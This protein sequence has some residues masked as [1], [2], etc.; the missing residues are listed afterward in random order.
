M[1]KSIFTIIMLCIAAIGMQAQETWTVAGS[2]A[3]FGSEWDVNDN[4]NNMTNTEGNTWTLV[5]TGVTL[6]TGVEYEF[7]VVQNHS[8]NVAYPANNWEIGEGQFQES[9]IYTVTITFYNEGDHVISVNCEKTGDY[10]TTYTVVGHQTL[11]GFDWKPGATANDMISQGDGTYKL[12]RKGLTLA[13]GDYP[14]KICQDHQWKYSWGDNGGSDNA[15]LNIWYDGSLEVKYDVTF[16]FNPNSDPKTVSAEAKTYA[17]NVTFSEDED[18]TAKLQSFEVG[19]NSITVNR[20]LHAGHWNTICLPFYMS[21]DNLEATFGSGWKL[22]KFTGCQGETMTFEQVYAVD[23][24]TP[25]L[26][27]VPGTTDITSF[28][29]SYDW[30]NRDDSRLEVNPNDAGYKMIGTLTP[31]DALESGKLFIANDKVYKST[32]K[33]KI[34]AMGAYFE[35]PASSTARSFTFSVD[36]EATGIISLGKDGSVNVVENTYDLQGHRVIAPQ[37]GIYIVNGKKVIK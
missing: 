7:K 11:T 23:H 14:Y 20:T 17:Y 8:W 4:A 37:H 33:S 12:E 22:A 25:Y 1:K 13:K 5:K 6:N 24:N 26:L 28:T 36:G 27:W 10:V 15:N 19:D 30:I 32:G 35:V 34:K 31:I 21:Y 2:V 29:V 18:I 16:T 3:I 9:G